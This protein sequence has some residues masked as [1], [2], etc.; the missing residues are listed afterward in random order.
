MTILFQIIFQII[1]QYINKHEPA[2]RLRPFQL[3]AS[4]LLA[5][6]FSRCPAVFHHRPLSS[7]VCPNSPITHAP[8]YASQSQHAQPAGASCSETS[9]AVTER[10]HWL[11]AVSRSRCSVTRRCCR[12]KPNTDPPLPSQSLSYA[13]LPPTK[14]FFLGKNLSVE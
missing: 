9:P 2:M 3:V 1:F 6:H 13:P 5:M 8:T 11:R 7:L 12:T 10:E 4:M 14:Q